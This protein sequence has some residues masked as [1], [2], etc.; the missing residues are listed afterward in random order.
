V[1][2]DATWNTKWSSAAD[3]RRPL[4]IPCGIPANLPCPY[5][6]AG[7]VRW[8]ATWNTKW[9]SSVG[10]SY[11]AVD[12]RE[13]LTNG[14]VPNINRGNTR[15]GPRGILAYNYH[16]LVADASVTFTAPSFPF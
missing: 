12:G 4:G 15:V 16:P 2:W 7:Q 3:G 10:G 13:T 6:V 8:D 9:S 1:R 11:L 5:L 14:A